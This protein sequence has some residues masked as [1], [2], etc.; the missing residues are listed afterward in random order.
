MAG[1][2]H[3]GIQGHAALPVNQLRYHDLF[4]TS[5]LPFGAWPRVGHDKRHPGGINA[6]F[7]DGHAATMSHNRM[8]KGF[9]SSI[10][11]RLRWFAVVDQELF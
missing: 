4:Y 3:G 10:G 5:Q 9:G 6:L 2:A 8:D 7:F 11:L 1:I